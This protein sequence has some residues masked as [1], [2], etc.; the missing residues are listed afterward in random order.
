MAVYF[1]NRYFYPD[2]SATGQMLADLA[3]HAA[4]RGL[5]VIVVTGRQRLDDARA[6]LPA[7]ERVQGLEVRRIWSTRFGR[8]ALAGRAVDYLSFHLAAL[9]FLLRWLRRGD[10]VVAATDPPLLGVTARWAARARGARLVNWLHDIFPEAAAALGVPG[11]QGLAGALLR[12]AR[13]ASLSA[14]A[15]NVVLGR[16]MADRVRRLCP[17]PAA[18][19]IIHNW[20]D[21]AAIAPL[22]HA[23]NELR[24]SLGLEGKVVVGYSGNLGR[25]HDLSALPSVAMA[26]T[27]LADLSFVVIGGGAGLA[28]LQEEVH[29]LGL[30]NVRFVP[31][32]PRE[33]LGE[34][35]CAVDIHLIS[36]RPALEGYVVPS[37]LYGILAAGRPSVHMGDAAGEVG[38]ILSAGACGLTVA[39]DS[40][41]AL[42]AALRRLHGDPALRR[43]M[44][45]NARA[46]FVER[47]DRPLAMERWM[48]V[49]G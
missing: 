4:A 3:F 5:T 47:F 18:V 43:R 48:K 49:L 42:E 8:G 29:R 27:G 16:V 36:L 35:L 32:Q 37:K 24:R 45:R 19:T 21:G 40:P 17:S 34:S 23:G 1:V 15:V 10:T 31:Y 9:L 46:L 30:G 39:G 25:A 22:A 2:H 6:R 26:L 44:G 12:R 41:A 11:V 7:R 20:S 13:N 14:A 33:C 28:S 38:Q